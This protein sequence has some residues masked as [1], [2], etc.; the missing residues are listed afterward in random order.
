[1]LQQRNTQTNELVI[2]YLTLR[3]LVGIIGLLLPFVLII[4]AVVMSAS[5]PDSMSGYYYTPMRNIFVGSLCALGIF[6]IAYVGY[7]E[8]DKW[9]TNI[10]G[11]AAVGVAFC[12]TT[13]SGTV[14]SSVR[15][16]GNIHVVFAMITFVSLGLMALRFAKGGQTP[17]AAPNTI[18][19][20]R[21]GLAFG[22]AASTTAPRAEIIAYRVCGTLILLCVL[23]AVL[24]NFLPVSVN[25]TWP[26]LFILE[27]IA[28]VS[29]GVSWTVKGSTFTPARLNQ[30]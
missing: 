26:T 27:A 4:G 22:A 1:M 3:R 24:T 14:T 6:L 11:L 2:D 8:V 29:F 17:D 15:T 18:G 19:Q 23:L 9:I 10:A 13:P 25:A 21:H 16:V 7:D 20:V 28:V 12:P 5:R 30:G